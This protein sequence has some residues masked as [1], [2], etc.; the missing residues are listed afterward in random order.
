MFINYIPSKWSQAMRCLTFVA[1]T[2]LRILVPK[3][4]LIRNPPGECADSKE[5]VR[6][7]GLFFNLEFYL[8]TLQ[9]PVTR[10]C[11]LV[12]PPHLR[13]AGTSM[14]VSGQEAFPGRTWVGRGHHLSA[15]D[16]PFLQGA[17][18]LAFIWPSCEPPF[19]LELLPSPHFKALTGSGIQATGVAQEVDS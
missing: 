19:L 15:N 12:K 13:H 11:W 3:R 1:G 9:Q 14:A 6:R 10:A 5:P 17:R 7:R 4:G 16:S 2:F 18:H 8:I